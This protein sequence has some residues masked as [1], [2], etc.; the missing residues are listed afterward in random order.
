[1]NAA[2]GA[3]PPLL[4]EP[5]TRRIPPG[6]EGIDLNELRKKARTWVGADLSRLSRDSL[7]TTLRKSLEDDQRRRRSSSARC[8][9][10]SRP[11]PPSIA[12]TA[13]RSTAR[14]SGS[15]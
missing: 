2:T 7:V 13:A 1:M 15:T 9:R 12:D 6:L 14:S 4:F 8:R 3:L 10:N 5:T 11:S